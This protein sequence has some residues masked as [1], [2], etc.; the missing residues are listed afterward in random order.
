VIDTL[1]KVHV[2]HAVLREAELVVIGNVNLA[3]LFRKLSQ[4]KE[5]S[6]DDTDEFS[7]NQVTPIKQKQDS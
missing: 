1:S 6:W 4:E 7:E 2:N 3:A 5:E